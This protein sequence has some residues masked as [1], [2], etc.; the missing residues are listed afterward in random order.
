MESCHWERESHSTVRYL[1][2]HALAA[3]QHLEIPSQVHCHFSRLSRNYLVF[4]RVQNIYEY[5]NLFC[6]SF[7][8]VWCLSLLP[9]TLGHHHQDTRSTKSSQTGSTAPPLS[10]LHISQRDKNRSTRISLCLASYFIDK[11]PVDVVRYSVLMHSLDIGRC[12]TM[13][14]LSL[15]PWR[16]YTIEHHPRSLFEITINCIAQTISIEGGR[17]SCGMLGAFIKQT[18]DISPGNESVRQDEILRA[19]SNKC[20]T[21]WGWSLI[22]HGL[23]SSP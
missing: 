8:L 14:E 2:H 12:Y 22:S 5:W 15:T 17:N 20:P 16:L 4:P 13:L 18:S 23:L 3:S 11:V 21:N 10:R 1:S 19:D 9:V 7:R 6:L